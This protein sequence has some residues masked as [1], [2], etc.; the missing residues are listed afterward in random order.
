MS[1]IFQ[2][3]WQDETIIRHSQRLLHSYQHW[4]GESV[5]DLNAS[6]EDIALTLFEAPFVMVSHGIEANPIFNY[7]NRQALKLWELTWNDFI[8]M[9]S[10]KSADEASQEDRQYL[11]TEAATKGFVRNYSGIR[12][13]NTGKRFYIK[14]TVL[15]NVFDENKQRCG[16][17]AFFSN[18]QYL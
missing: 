17:A 9:P 12:I 11:L 15:W 1:D 18:W 2:N 3:P 10:R 16:Q 13:S 7:A 4:T 14:D 8:Q 5:L 6:P